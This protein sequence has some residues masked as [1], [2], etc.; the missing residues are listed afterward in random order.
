MTFFG[1][2]RFVGAARRKAQSASVNEL[3]LSEPD[4]W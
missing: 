2:F 3:A 4:I 1:M